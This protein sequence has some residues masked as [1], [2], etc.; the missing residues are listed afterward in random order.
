MLD[1]HSATVNWGEPGGVDEPATVIQG[2][3]DGNVIADHVY[4]TGGVYTLTLTLT[5]DDTGT[6]TSTTLAVVVGA[7]VNNGVLQVVG[8]DEAN[9]VTVN[10]QGNR[11]YKVHADFFSEGN[12]RTFDAATIDYIQMWLCDGDDHAKIAGN[13]NIPASI[14]GGAGNDHLNGGGARNILIGGPGEDRLV[15]G[16]EDDILIGGTTDYDFNDV[17]LLA[18]LDEWNSGRTYPDRVSNIRTGAG[19]ILGGTGFMLVKG[20]TVFDDGEFDK[21][22][23]SSG[24]DWFFFDPGEDDVTGKKAFEEAN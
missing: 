21:L 23:G 17:A 20:V 13:I 18:L 5:D 6:D 22:T 15:G 9:H 10:K 24:R 7:G 8:S 3:G 14:Y 4:S 11:L 19:P 1:T 16:G 2:S 12:H